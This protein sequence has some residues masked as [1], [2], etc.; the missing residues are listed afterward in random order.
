[1]PSPRPPLLS[2]YLDYLGYFLGVA[3]VG[4]GVLLWP[5]APVWYSGMVLVGML[6]FVCAAALH[7]VV[8]ARPRP[9]MKPARGL[10]AAALLAVGLGLLFGGIQHLPHLPGRAAPL[11]LVGIA[12]SFVA[13]VMRSPAR[14]CVTVVESASVV[15]ALAAAVF[16]LLW[17][18]NG[19]APGTSV[20]RTPE[21]EV[22]AGS[23][24]VAPRTGDAQPAADAERSPTQDAVRAAHAGH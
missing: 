6:S 9:S 18:L 7:E 4:N 20:P 5:D 10:A 24:V 22:P 12:V 2:G 17:Q 19:A 15:A 3:L 16:V 13:Y 1:M 21:A 14:D 11:I 8:F 23:L